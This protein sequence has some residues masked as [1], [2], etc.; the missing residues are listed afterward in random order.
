MLLHFRAMKLGVCML[1][2]V[3]T[4]LSQPG[5]QNGSAASPA[6]TRQATIRLR[7]T[8]A[9]RREQARSKTDLCA[10][11]QAGGSAAIGRCLI[12][13]FKTTEREYLTYVRCIGALL[14]PLVSR[15]SGTSPSDGPQRLPFDA[16]E[17]TWRT[18]RD[19][20]CT[21]MATQWEG[22]NQAPI[23]YAN[24]RL[25]LTWNHLN[26]LADLYADLWH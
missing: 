19:Q 4:A 6:S 16:A 18:Y 12:A 10:A 3:L 21:S 11:V 22:G 8:E 2:C 23:A 7:G 20:S 5:N 24:C 26:E 9:L 25:T 1:L 13:E 17:D 14:R 15:H